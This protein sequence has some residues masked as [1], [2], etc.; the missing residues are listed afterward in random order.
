[1]RIIFKELTVASLWGARGAKAPPPRLP[2]VPFLEEE[3]NECLINFKKNISSCVSKFWTSM[4][5]SGAILGEGVQAPRPPM[6]MCKN[7]PK[8]A[9]KITA[10]APYFAILIVYVSF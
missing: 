9:K 4:L 8:N 3:K 7:A 10:A 2:E 1:M 5:T 6:K